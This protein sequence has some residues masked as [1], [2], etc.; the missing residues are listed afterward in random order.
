[1]AQPMVLLSFLGHV[2]HATINAVHVAASLI[3]FSA[4][5]LHVAMMRGEGVVLSLCDEKDQ[6]VPTGVRDVWVA[7]GDLYEGSSCTAKGLVEYNLS[8]VTTTTNIAGGALPL[9]I[10]LLSCHFTA[11]TTTP[12][13]SLVVYADNLAPPVSSIHVTIED[14]IFAQGASLL[15]RLGR[16]PNGS[17]ITVFRN[18]FNVSGS[19][20]VAQSELSTYDTES[21]YKPSSTSALMA[22]LVFHGR[23]LRFEDSS[24]IIVVNNTINCWHPSALADASAASSLFSNATKKFYC[25]SADQSASLHNTLAIHFVYVYGA[26]TVLISN[27]S[28][29]SI[30]NNTLTVVT[31]V[32]PQVPPLSPGNTCPDV[33]PIA[34]GR[35]QLISLLAGELIVNASSVLSIAGNALSYWYKGSTM[36]VNWTN[37]DP[38]KPF[39]VLSDN[40]IVRGVGGLRPVEVFQP[41]EA[42]ALISVVTKYIYMYP[43]SSGVMR[44]DGGAALRVTANAMRVRLAGAYADWGGVDEGGS[45]A[46]DVFGVLVASTPRWRWAIAALWRLTSI[47]LS[48]TLLP[49][50]CAPTRLCTRPRASDAPSGG[51]GIISVSRWRMRVRRLVVAHQS[52]LPLLPKC[53]LQVTLRL[54][55]WP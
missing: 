6:L 42:V 1:M 27:S 2:M 50:R 15:F 45:T 14:C 9:R 8:S 35:C 28:S 44:V 51:R 21:R 31:M 19:N 32:P 55:R 11:T 40:V 18:T 48:R 54:L 20:V 41:T 43:G 29:L 16:L 10:V 53:V 47:V 26:E 7:G 38:N 33:Y 3:L 4:L 17:N 25:G 52:Q 34:I 24:S 46:A 12:N 49:S 22:G 36:G 23:A 13:A 5:L 37:P 30:A 39:S